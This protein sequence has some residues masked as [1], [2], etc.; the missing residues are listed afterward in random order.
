ME[1]ARPRIAIVEDQT[2]VSEMLREYLPRMLHCEVVSVS[3][4]GAAARA[5]I[6]R[7]R[8]DIVLLDL[9]LP[10]MPPRQVIEAVLAVAGNAKVIA[11]TSLLNPVTLRLV[12]QFK[13][14]G[15]LDKLGG[16]IL[17]LK[18]AITTVLEGQ[19]YRPAWFRETLREARVM[20]HSFV[21]VLTERE[22]EVLALI[23]EACSDREIAARRGGSVAAAHAH[24][25]HLMEKLD[26][27]STPEL[28]RYAIDQGFAVA[29]SASLRR[30]A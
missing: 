30:P 24:R 19:P 25:V 2:I 23:G 1:P 22:N 13:L 15:Y 4:S 28:M 21:N 8:P 10:D 6:P 14:P 9:G 12:D 18:E 29:D 5:D 16:N 20:P 7:L 27:H 3:S 11:F 26:L 17:S